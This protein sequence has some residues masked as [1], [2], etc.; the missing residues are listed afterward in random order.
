MSKPLF[1]KRHYE[2]IVGWLQPMCTTDHAAYALAAMFAVD[3]P[4][5]NPVKFI[6][7]CGSGYITQAPEP[8][9]CQLRLVFDGKSVGTI[10][11]AVLAAL[12][13]E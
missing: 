13:R 1:Q 3:N 5:F 6:E 7:A 8:L 10:M 9:T 11:Q 4:N 2:A 12:P